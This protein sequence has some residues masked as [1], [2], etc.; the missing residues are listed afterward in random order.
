MPTSQPGSLREEVDLHISLLTHIRQNA[1]QDAAMI[2]DWNRETKELLSVR[3]RHGHSAERY[4]TDRRIESRID[5]L[6]LWQSLLYWDHV[7]VGQ[8]VTASLL[9][10]EDAG[11][12]DEELRSLIGASLPSFCG[13]C[14][15]ILCLSGTY[16]PQLCRADCGVLSLQQDYTVQDLEGRTIPYLLWTA[17]TA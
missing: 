1:T 16:R 9:V 15:S 11:V 5:E 7:K 17:A 10:L 2:S 14:H 12:S 13:L 3:H 6:Q 8:W 4:F